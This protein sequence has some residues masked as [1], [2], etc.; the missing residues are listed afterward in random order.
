MCQ[1]ITKESINYMKM[2]EL[3]AQ[4]NAD[5]AKEQ[6]FPLRVVPIDQPANHSTYQLDLPALEAHIFSLLGID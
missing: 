2:F 1:Q 6:P 5:N 4:A 3:L